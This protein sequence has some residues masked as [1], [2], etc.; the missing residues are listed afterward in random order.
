MRKNN[1]N[2]GVLVGDFFPSDRERDLLGSED[3][4]TI[5]QYPADILGYRTDE[6]AFIIPF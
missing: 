1:F 5:Y 3:D 6:E 2:G 4:A